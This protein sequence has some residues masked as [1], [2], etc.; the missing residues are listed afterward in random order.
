MLEAFRQDTDAALLDLN[1]RVGFL[2]STV[3]AALPIVAEARLLWMENT[4]VKARTKLGTTRQ[5]LCQ[6]CK[7]N[8]ALYLLRVYIN[9]DAPSADGDP[10]YTDYTA[11]VRA[12][13][14]YLGLTSRDMDYLKER[15]NSLG[16]SHH[17]KRET[18]LVSP[19]GGGNESGDKVMVD[20]FRPNSKQGIYARHIWRVCYD[21]VSV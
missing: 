11:H 18:I 15:L 9:S 5:A 1:S 14:Y 4:V 16:E 2:E 7:S 8:I 17:E 20:S 21:R 13:S 12:R 10:K 19:F 6:Y 3:A